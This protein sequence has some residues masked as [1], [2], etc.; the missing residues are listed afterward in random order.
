MNDPLGVRVLDR[1]ADLHEQLET[2]ARFE[3]VSVAVLRDWVR[4]RC[5]N[6]A[7]SRFAGE[8]RSAGPRQAVVHVLQER[9]FHRPWASLSMR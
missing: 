5:Q 6:N 4:P 9:I 8:A 1:G 3:M 2:L 7:R